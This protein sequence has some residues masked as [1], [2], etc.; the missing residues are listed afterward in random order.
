M[1]TEKQSK[2]WKLLNDSIP[3]QGDSYMRT[4]VHLEDCPPEYLK[5]PVTN[6]KVSK[7][8]SIVSILSKLRRSRDNM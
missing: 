3:E 6:V 5:P 2:P 8:I 4:G 7:N 1:Y